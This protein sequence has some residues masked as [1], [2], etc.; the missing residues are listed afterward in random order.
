[1]ALE[2][3]QFLDYLE[4][5][6]SS[7]VCSCCGTDAWHMLIHDVEDIKN[8]QLMAFSLLHSDA[9]KDVSAALDVLVIVCTNCGLV[10][11]HCVQKVESDFSSF[12]EAADPRH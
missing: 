10:R 2:K 3:H 9:K 7:M 5:R 12:A 11:M 1:M 4:A 8:Q 6:G